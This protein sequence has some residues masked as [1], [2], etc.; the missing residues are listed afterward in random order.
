M[1]N[2]VDIPVPHS[3]G[4]W[5]NERVSRIVEIIKDYDPNLEVAW[6]PPEKRE[7]GD[8]A[9]AIIENYPGKPRQV[10]FYV[11]SEAEFDERVLTRIFQGD[12][13]KHDVLGNL[14]ASNRAVE[15]IEYK[16]RMEQ[17]EE[18]YDHMKH[19]LKSPLNTYRG[20]DGRVYHAHGPNFL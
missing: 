1:N 13:T 9:F 15:A 6:I 4:R 5:I 18:E 16:K 11:D 7:P 14:E 12:T 17:L 8:S 10:A 20:K 3:D 2:M 19:V